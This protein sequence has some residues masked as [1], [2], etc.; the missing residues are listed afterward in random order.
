MRIRGVQA[1]VRPQDSDLRKVRRELESGADDVRPAPLHPVTHK[2]PVRD[3]EVHRRE[4][5]IRAISQ[6]N[7]TGLVVNDHFGR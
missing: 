5:F 4:I 6:V 1:E 2:G 7:G 3:A